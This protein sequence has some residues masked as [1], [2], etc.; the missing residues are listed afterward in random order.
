M[1]RTPELAERI[2][3]ISV[4]ATMRVFMAAAALRAQGVDV[5]DFSAGEPDF[6]TPEHIKQA[7]VR[8]IQENFTRYTSAGGT[9]ELKRAVCD[10][11]AQDFGT[12]YQPP[13]CVVSV[14]GKHAV[15]NLTQV[16]VSPGDEVLIPVPFWVT[17][18]DAVEYAGGQCVFVETEER[19]GFALTAALIERQ[20]TPRTRMVVINS[21]CNPSGAV[22]SREEFGRL[23]EMTSARGIYLLSDECYARLLYEGAPFS[24]ASL[25]GSKETVVVAGSLSKTYAMT[26]WRIGYG[27]GP[28]SII[29]AVVKLQS[30]S[31]SNPTS[32]SQKAAVEA[33][34]GPQEAVDRMLGEYRQRRDYVVRR[35]RAIPGVQC[36]EPQGAFYAYPNI[37]VAL[38][39]DGVRNTVEFSERLLEQARV[40]VVP[41]EA[42]GT[43]EHIRISFATSMEQL[44][45]GLNRLHQFIADLSA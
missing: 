17:Y 13:E 27:L 39:R 28:E 40:A 30:H 5:A 41:G 3:R 45:R 29:Q 22:L 38:G 15:F 43:Q 7:G 42:F 10:R 2:S 14:G 9:E 34:R 31:T 25:P 33:L 18:K 16:L 35:L 4:S 6:P 20:L 19:N 23:L 12:A 1:S 36:T 26:G 21:P 44:E 24:V 11:H 37:R 8:A 32:I